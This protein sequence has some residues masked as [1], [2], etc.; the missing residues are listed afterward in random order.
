MLN[1]LVG[2]LQVEVPESRVAIVKDNKHISYMYSVDH[3]K[4][5]TMLLFVFWKIKRHVEMPR[6]QRHFKVL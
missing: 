2:Y 6:L 1:D 3:I 4:E 5:P